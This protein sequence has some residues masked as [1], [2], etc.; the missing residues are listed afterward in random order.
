[1]SA[2]TLY[3][4]CAI[5]LRL[6]KTQGREIALTPEL[7]E[8]VPGAQSARLLHQ[9]NEE[10]RASYRVTDS[11][12]QTFIVK[13]EP[14]DSMAENDA[15]GFKFWQWYLDTFRKQKHL[16]PLNLSVLNH[17]TTKSTSQYH[18]LV[19]EDIPGIPLD[20][21]MKDESI[22]AAQRA[23]KYAEWLELVQKLD[24][25]MDTHLREEKEETYNRNSGELLFH[26]KAGALPIPTT[27][28]GGRGRVT[29]YLK[30]DNV[31][32]T[33]DGRFVIFDPY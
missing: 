15:R 25:E 14:A 11:D 10:N 17:V 8:A 9:K 28:S 19:M 16:D 29:L 13:K 4:G 5:S 21:Y 12:G 32:V 2:S 33:P 31:L 27:P 23:T 26:L 20:K 1:L 7:R 30:P 22:P 6:A 18:Y 24:P 3:N